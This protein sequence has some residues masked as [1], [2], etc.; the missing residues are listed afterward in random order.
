MRVN[1]MINSKGFFNYMSS[2]SQSSLYRNG[3][4]MTNRDI[5]GSDGRSVRVYFE[6]HEM[7]VKNARESSIVETISLDKNGFQLLPSKIDNLDIDFFNNQEVIKN[8]YRQES[9]LIPLRA[10]YYKFD[11]HPYLKQKLQL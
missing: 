8:Y 5:G 9:N 2:D 7:K 11:Q 10:K 3:K 1:R 4:V 6:K